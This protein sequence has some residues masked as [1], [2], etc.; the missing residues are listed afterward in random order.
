MGEAFI[1]G[2]G[3]QEILLL[4]LLLILLFC[5]MPFL[6]IDLLLYILAQAFGLLR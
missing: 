1:P 2:L 6:A 5:G 3:L 4:L